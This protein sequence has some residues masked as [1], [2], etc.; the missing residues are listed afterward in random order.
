MATPVGV[1]HQ[2]NTATLTITLEDNIPSGATL[3]C[4]VGAAGSTHDILTAQIASLAPAF[5]SAGTTGFFTG[6]NQ[7]ERVFEQTVSG[8]LSSGDTVTVTMEDAGQGFTTIMWAT[9]TYKT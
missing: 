9:L 3:R 8:G 5:M 1:H 4:V 6:S 2:H 7:T